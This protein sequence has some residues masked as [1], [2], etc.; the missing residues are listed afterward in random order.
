[1]SDNVFIV[2]FGAQFYGSGRRAS[3]L[4]SEFCAVQVQ[5]GLGKLSAYRIREFLH[6]RGFET[7]VLG[8]NE[9]STIS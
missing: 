5:L 8:P 2:S 7:Y 4:L 6:F 3:G 9:V 1:M